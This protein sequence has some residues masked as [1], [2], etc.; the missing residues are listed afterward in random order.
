VRAAIAIGWGLELDGERMA[1]GP[2]G[3][4]LIPPE[5]RHRVAGRM[6]ILS[7]VVPPFD[8]T[9]ESCDRG[10]DVHGFQVAPHRARDRHEI[11]QADPRSRTA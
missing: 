3:A 6:T 9:N 4:V 7:V 10:R 5:V 2:G 1:V 8:P 11:E